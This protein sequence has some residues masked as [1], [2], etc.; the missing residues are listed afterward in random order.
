V[1]PLS[2]LIDPALLA[3]V[4]QAIVFAMA[5][6]LL[7]LVVLLV[8]QKIV[9]ERRYR[10]EHD[11]A[12]RHARAL[13]NGTRVQ[14][15]AVDPRRLSQRRALA[16]ALRAAW[17]DVA[18]EQL[19]SA[20]WYGDL[21]RRVQKDT[22]S[23]AWGERVAAFEMLG[24]LGAAELRSFLEQA[25][26]RENH[27]Q[28]YA[29]CLA[30]LA[31]F[32]EQACGLATVW[33]QLQTK[34]PLSGSFNEGL[35]RIAIDALSRH[36]SLEA[37]AGGVQQLL[38]DASPHDPLTLDLI[39]AIGKSGLA[40]LVPQLVTLCDGAQAPKSLRIA[41]VRAVGMLQ[42][43]HPLLL[44]AL[45]DRDWEVQASGAKYLRGTTPGVIVGLSDCLTSPA[46][47]VRHNAAT[48]LAALGQQGRGILEQALASSDAFAREIS[49]YALRTLNSPDAL[50]V[51]E[52]SDAPR[53]LERA[54][55]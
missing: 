10:E 18:M 36:S 39:R 53:G 45:S 25:A 6:S 8:L 12:D 46:F 29:A 24:D 26:H 34:P 52:R 3:P 22:M 35:F 55:A 44:N 11:A 42:P 31:K 2:R 7:S 5:V 32:A 13:A 54:Y 17:T 40:S 50:R 21:V 23:K 49:R 30:C 27:P 19:R 37:A 9:L 43:D 47:Y 51:P 33:N 38:A 41:C 14:D 4:L 1:N 20:P 48:T 15:L 28:A 16:R